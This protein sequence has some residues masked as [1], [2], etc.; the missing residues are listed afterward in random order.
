MGEGVCEGCVGGSTGGGGGVVGV[1]EE[2]EGFDEEGVAD[3]FPE[4]VG[5]FYA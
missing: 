2:G 4:G 1:L 3:A 5:C